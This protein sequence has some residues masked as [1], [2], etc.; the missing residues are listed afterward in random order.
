[1]TGLASFGISTAKATVRLQNVYRVLFYK[2]AKAPTMALHLSRGNRYF[3]MGAQVC[4][5]PRIVLVQRLFKPGDVAV[6]NCTAKEFGFHR[7]EQIIGIDHE[8]KARTPGIA[9][10]ETS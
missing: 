2:F 5:R 10:F 1:M 4:E 3:R 9:T 8:I 6:F 7:V